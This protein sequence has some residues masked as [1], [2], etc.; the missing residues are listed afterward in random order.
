MFFLLVIGFSINQAKSSDF[1]RSSATA[2][3]VRLAAA[4]AELGGAHVF[5][6]AVA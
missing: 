2:A 6:V 5:G 1:A 3:V 4:P